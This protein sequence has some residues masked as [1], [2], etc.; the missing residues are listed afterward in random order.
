MIRETSS[1]TGREQEM[2]LVEW[3]KIQRQV[4]DWLHAM[5]EVVLRLEEA[6]ADWLLFH[7][8]YSMLL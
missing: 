6:A 4:A 7:A 3:L 2:A 5:K 8:L 1:K